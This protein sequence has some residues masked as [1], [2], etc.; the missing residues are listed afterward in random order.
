M[1]ASEVIERLGGVARAANALGIKH[2]SVCGW[3][4]RGKVP[5]A[6]VAQVARLINV[7]PHE[8]RPDIFPEPEAVS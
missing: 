3:I 8:I 6:R 4:V 1:Q 2:P 7:P 5:A